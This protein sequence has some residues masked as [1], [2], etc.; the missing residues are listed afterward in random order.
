MA[1]SKMSPVRCELSVRVTA[2]TCCTIIIIVVV[3]TCVLSSLKRSL[4]A[5]TV[6]NES[7]YK[8]VL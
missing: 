4:L 1:V 3:T 8:K 7:T 5:R 6:R 2:S